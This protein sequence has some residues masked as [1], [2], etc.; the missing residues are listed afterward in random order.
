MRIL[1]TGSTGMVGRNILA[2]PDTGGYEWDTPDEIQLDLTDRV[3]VMTYL[4]DSRPDMVI[5]VAGR[6]GGIQANIREP[7]QFFTENMDMGM[8]L[9][10]AA[11]E[12]GVTRLLN[13]ASSCIYPREG[14]NPLQEKA[15]LTGELEPTNEGYALA[16]IGTMR[17]CTYIN[18]QD[19][20]YT[21]KT[22]IPCNQYGRWDN[23]NQASSHMIPAVIRKLHLAALAKQDRIDIWGD[24][25]ARR[26]FMFAGDLADCILEAVRRFDTLPLQ[27]NVGMG[28][29]YT[30]NEYYREIAAVVGYEGG[31][32]H[33]LSKQ[34]GML[35]KLVDVS[36]QEQ[37]GWCPKTSL[38][39]GLVATYEWYLEHLDRFRT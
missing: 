25:N 35:R 12:A 28:N 37:W 15:I 33:D 11:R 1:L 18:R 21:Y 6:V 20:N 24:G 5:H 3:A 9:V 34:V 36:R 32:Y 8:N 13:L 26:E 29:D 27:M 38:T 23:F 14:K 30:I 17:L 31:F 19:K 7:V 4:D 10:L 2:H 22:L 39:S 16:K